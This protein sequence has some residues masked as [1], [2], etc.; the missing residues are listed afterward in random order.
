MRKPLTIILLL[1]SLS[2]FSQVKEMHATLGYLVDKSPEGEIEFIK[3]QEKCE[4][5]WKKLNNQEDYSKLTTE[6]RK[7]LEYCSEDRLGYYDILGVGCSWYCGGGL[8]TTSASSELKPYKGLKY[9]AS[10]AD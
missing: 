9:K 8:D 3:A 4:T 2:T 1:F 10:N 5:I 6:E 7:L